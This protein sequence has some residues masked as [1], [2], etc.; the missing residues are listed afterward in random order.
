M[1]KEIIINNIAFK[2]YMAEYWIDNK[3]TL[4]RIEFDDDNNI[5]LFK[6]LK[7]ETGKNGHKRVEIKINTKPKK[8]LIHRA[9]YQVWVGELKDDLVIE[10][11]DGNPANNHVSNLK[12]STQKE[13]IQTAI[14]QNRFY[15]MWHNKTHIMVYDKL[16]DET[17]GYECVKDFLI[18]I[19]APKYMVDHGALSGL[20]KRKEY[21][22]RFIIEKIGRKGRS[23]QTSEKVS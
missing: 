5:E 14:A 8:V 10:H 1:N 4:A 6:V 12:Q 15:Q 13:N 22:D 20:N 2:N 16:K 11:L 19:G 7:Q 21:K 9:V 23:S 3:G 17:K 18:D